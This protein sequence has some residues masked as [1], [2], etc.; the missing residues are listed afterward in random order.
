MGAA[1]LNLFFLNP[2]FLGG[3]TTFTVH[4]MRGLRGAGCEACLYR[5]GKRTETRRRDFGYGEVYR[6]LA[7]E[8]ALK[9]AL[10]GSLITAT[11]PRTVPETNA[12]VAAGARVVIHDPTHLKQGWD[13]RA[14]RRPLVIRESMLDHLQDGV[15]LP[16]PYDPCGLSPPSPLAGR[17]LPGVTCC[18]ITSNKH[19]DIVLDANRLLDARD[20]IV[21][22]GAEHS[23]YVHFYLR[24][25]YPEYVSPP[26]DSFPREFGFAVRNITGRSVFTVDLSTLKGDGGGTQYSFLEAADGGSCLV[27]NR[28]WLRPGGVIVPGWN[29]LAVENG[30]ELADLLREFR[31]GRAALRRLAGRVRLNLRGLMAGHGGAAV[32][33][34]W[35]KELTPLPRPAAGPAKGRPLL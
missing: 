11:S 33:G 30:A 29:C 4:L 28:G 25:R 24:P 31:A 15:F 1:R 18:R 9:L 35:L 14:A 13:W 6:N 23:S 16:H 19:I 8:D 2:P 21:L 3:Q 7:L 10:A 20:R 32:A 17:P 34:R 12:M 27:V 5:I 26:R 22:F